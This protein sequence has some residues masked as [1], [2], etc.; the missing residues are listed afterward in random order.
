ML[1]LLTDR[2]AEAADVAAEAGR[3]IRPVGVTVSVVRGGRP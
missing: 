1:S 3:G 2:V